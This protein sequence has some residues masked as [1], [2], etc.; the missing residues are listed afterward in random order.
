M[1]LSTTTVRYL[2]ASTW[3]PRDD[4]PN[5]MH[6]PGA[7]VH[8]RNTGGNLLLLAVWSLR[9]QGLVEIDQLRRVEK[10]GLMVM[11]GRSFTRVR[12]LPGEAVRLGGLEGRLLTKMRTRKPGGRIDRL[13]RK[14]SKDDEWGLRESLGEL[15]YD[16][17]SPWGS[18][19]AMC[20]AEAKSAG[21]VDRG[22][23]G[24]VE[25]TDPEGVRAL[26][27][28]D[29]EI[30]EARR[31]HREREAELDEAVIS[32]CFAALDWAHNPGND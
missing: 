20:F 2:F 7:K 27:A 23:K 5:G 15:D 1:P 32:D 9:E 25:I 16:R 8:A 21:L 13:A 11:G 26:E 31:R 4:S 12:P 17:W 24:R 19:A 10:E 29:A 3:A 28:R 14:L 18:V 22:E 30:V 6:V